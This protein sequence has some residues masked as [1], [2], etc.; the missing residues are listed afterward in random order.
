MGIEEKKIARSEL[1]DPLD[2][3]R[4]IVSIDNFT[5]AGFTDCAVPGYRANSHNYKEGGAHLTPR[6]ILDTLEYTPVTLS[7]GVTGDTSF[8]KWATGHFDLVQNGQGTNIYSDVKQ[9]FGFEV[10]TIVRN[11]GIPQDLGIVSSSPVPTVNPGQQ[12]RRKVRIKHV[13]RAG[14]TIVEYVLHGAWPIEYKPASDFSS[15]DDDGF[16][17][18][19]ITLAYESFDVRYTGTEGLLG[20]LGVNSIF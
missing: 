5:R 15:N 18:E 2:K 10:P 16:S 14:Q 1:Q 19:T 7:R 3:Y 11:F 4:W 12:Y 20:S 8:N 13:N 6:Q 17:I 9:Q